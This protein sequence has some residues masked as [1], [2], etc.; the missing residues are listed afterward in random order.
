[1]FGIKRQPRPAE[2]PVNQEHYSGQAL[3]T[4]LTNQE[5]AAQQLSAGV[6]QVH[7]TTSQVLTVIQE[8]AAGLDKQAERLQEAVAVVDEMSASAQEVASFAQTVLQS[9]DG[10][11]SAVERGKT[12]IQSAV[13]QMQ[14]IK[15]TVHEAMQMVNNLTTRTRAIEQIVAVIRE[16]ADRTNLL[17]F[18]AAIEA[19]RAGE[20]GRGFSVVAQ[21]V[22]KLADQSAESAKRIFQLISEIEGE[23]VRVEQSMAASAQEADKGSQVAAHVDESFSQIVESIANSNKLVNE[24]TRVTEVQAE[25]SEKI[26][27]AIR[28]IS[29]VADEVLRLTER[30]TLDAEQHGASIAN[31]QLLTQTAEAAGQYFKQ[32]T[33]Q[34]APPQTYR[35]SISDNPIT[36][37]PALGADATCAE[38]T[39]L[40]FSGLVQFGEDT[41][42]IPAIAENWHLDKDGLTWIFH[43]RRGVHFHHGREVTATD[44]KYSFE[45]ILHPKTKSPHTWL[46]DAVVGAA[47]FAAGKAPQVSGIKVL[48]PQTLAITLLKPYNPFLANLAY[49]AASVVP[50]ELVEKDPDHFARHPVGTGPFVFV[51]WKEGEKISLTANPEYFEGR[52]FMDAIEIRI[53]GKEESDTDLFLQG[54]LEHIELGTDYDRIGKDPNWQ[55]YI[56]HLPQ[57]SVQYL[58]FVHIRKTPV[59]DRRVRQAI[60]HAINKQRFIEKFFAGRATEANGPLPPG[61]LGYDP[62]FK[63]YDYNPE[64]AKQLLAAAGYPHGLKDPLVMHVRDAKATVERAEFIKDELQKIGIPVKIEPLPWRE[65]IN[66]ENMK[67]CDMYLLS[68]IGDTGDPD[69]FLYPLFHSQSFG[70]SGNRGYYHNPGLDEKIVNAQGIRNPVKREQAYREIVKELV[71]DAPWVFLFHNDR[72]IVHQ[73]Y[74]KALRQ[75][76]LGRFKLHRVWFD[77]LS[78]G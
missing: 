63:R 12:A 58:G 56:S 51:A 5:R 64:K 34:K 39:S 20:A 9:S 69:N 54:S 71:E 65:L 46:F 26:I 67:T 23:T 6:N 10:T 1:M 40:V 53:L 52:P 50:Q 77:P 47:E 68:W 15:T 35:F 41:T 57:L 32:Q 59:S 62:R 16:L 31:L 75:H 37:D 29:Q 2:Q 60:N 49:V 21:E 74:V 14:K 27:D 33:R 70:G 18:N 24:I 11:L 28:S 7:A 36:L 19:A 4:A 72:Y 17:S 30:A 25:G 78:K 61:V 43:L 13:D 44:F 8:I 66:E 73:P 48:D 38:V 45:R 76:I 22:K 55:P 3:A 42:I